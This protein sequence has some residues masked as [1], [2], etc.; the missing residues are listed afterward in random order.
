MRVKD[1]I[2]LMKSHNPNAI[3]RFSVANDLSPD[4]EERWFAED[5]VHDCFGDDSEVTI[6]LVV[7][8]NM[9][10]AEEAE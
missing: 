8:S 3:V 7:R 2:R 6:C 10:P 9:E 1:L 4:P 5:G